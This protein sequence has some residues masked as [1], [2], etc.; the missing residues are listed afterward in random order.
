[1]FP[2]LADTTPESL[3]DNRFRRFHPTESI[4]MGVTAP[5]ADMP[6]SI[7][8]VYSNTNYQLLSQFLELVTGPT[9]EKCITENVIERAGLR[10]TELPAGSDVS[11]PHSQMYEGG[12]A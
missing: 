5:A 11:G 7:P 2:S 1:V 10:D 9:A 3:E 4:E 12:S 6:G 8:G